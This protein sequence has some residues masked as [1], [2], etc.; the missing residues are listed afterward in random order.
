ML[1]PFLLYSFHVYTLA[2]L[3]DIVNVFGRV[4]LANT[5]SV[6]NKRI[7]NLYQNQTKK[8]KISKTSKQ[9]EQIY[10]FRLNLIHIKQKVAEIEIWVFC[11]TTVRSETSVP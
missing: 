4:S 10:M 7:K 9:L 5:R 8:P 11:R 2:N 6:S 1:F 3:G